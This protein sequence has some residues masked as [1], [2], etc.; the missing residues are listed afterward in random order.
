MNPR[1]SFSLIRVRDYIAIQTALAVLSNS[2]FRD[3]IIKICKKSGRDV[4]T[5]VPQFAYEFADTLIMES[6]YNKPKDS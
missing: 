4:E 3:S 6:T 1:D 5:A 2:D